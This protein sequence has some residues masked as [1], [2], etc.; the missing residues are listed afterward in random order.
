[1]A[2]PITAGIDIGSLSTEVVILQGDKVLSYSIQPTGANGYR[3]AETAMDIALEKAGL[4]LGDIAG[5]VATGYGRINAPYTD[6]RVTEITCHAR[7]AHFLFPETRTIIDIGGQDSK[8]IQVNKAGK[9]VDFV[10]N[11]KC[12]AGTGRFLEVM[13]RALEVDLEDMGPLGE[14][15]RKKLVISSMCTVF[16]ES[17]VVSLIAR[18]EAKH[19]I[20]RAI[21][22]AVAERV[23]GQVERIGNIAPITMTGGVAKNIGVVNSLNRLLGVRM[24]LPEEPQIIGALG[25]ALI[26]A[27]I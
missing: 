11:D 15:S 5:C 22:D 6:K 20:I 9:V 18:G 16:A 1:M 13:A 26:A 8:V 10:M 17:E 14:R 2:V 19:D 27:G 4:S 25:A 24:N 21:H 3:A 7:G 23:Y 12:A